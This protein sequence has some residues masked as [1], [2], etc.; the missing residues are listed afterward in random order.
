MNLQTFKTE[1]S[2]FLRT[3]PKI[4]HLVVSCLLVVVIGI[5]DSVTGPEITLSVFYLLP[6][7]LTAFYVGLK[8]GII[9]SIACIISYLIADHI[10]SI[11]Y[12][13]AATPYWNSVAR[14]LLFIIVSYFLAKRKTAEQKLSE[15]EERFRLLVEGVCDYSIIMLDL[16]GKIVSWNTG[17]E[18]AFGY[19]S[20]E[21]L[22]K[23]FS[24]F[25]SL[26]N[27]ENKTEDLLHS[28]SSQEVTNYE[29]WCV[30][31]NNSSFWADIVITALRD[32]NEN[33]RG[34]SMLTKDKTERR[35]AERSGESLCRTASDRSSD[36]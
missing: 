2:N 20:T 19:N 16:Q 15:S 11:S 35:K 28:A 9:I 5:A 6:I 17:A 10:V 26:H 1:F 22:G 31:K 34:F 30:H 36:P 8:P 4:F 14:L 13:K 18:R 32:K 24:R 3:K 33:L 21:I 27:N 25:F 23:N 7:F 12:A 29:G